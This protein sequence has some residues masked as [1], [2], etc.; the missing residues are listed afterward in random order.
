MVKGRKR[1]NGVPK[2]LPMIGCFLSDS[3]SELLLSPHSSNLVLGTDHFGKA[4]NWLQ[5]RLLYCVPEIVTEQSRM[6]NR[7]LLLNGIPSACDL[8]ERRP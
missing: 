4:V 3:E 7:R 6:L 8:E 2:I 5:Y 1:V